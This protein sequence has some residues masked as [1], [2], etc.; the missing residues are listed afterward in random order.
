MQS[1]RKQNFDEAV[2]TYD[3][4]YRTYRDCGY[5]VMPIPIMAV[6]ARADFV[7]EEVAKD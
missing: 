7:P 1:E 5:E 4:M 2:R 3:L 6:S